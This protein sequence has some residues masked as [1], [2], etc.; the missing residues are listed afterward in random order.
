[1]QTGVY[2]LSRRLYLYTLGEPADP[3]ARDIVAFA[4]SDEAQGAVAEAGFVDQS[5]EMEDPQL[6]AK[7]IET[8]MG[9]TEPRTPAT[10]LS[11]LVED[12]RRV[13]RTSVNFRFAKGGFELDAKARLDAGRVA[14]FLRSPETS[15][16][17]WYLVGFADATGDYASNLALS[18]RRAGAVAN[19]LR[20]LGVRVEK[21]NIIPRGWVAPIACNS[22]EQGRALNRRVELWIGEPDSSALASGSIA[23]PAKKP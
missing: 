14:R 21:A 16:K 7:W 19:A 5:V 22:D 9:R 2:P 23:A 20:S 13:T 18:G 4:K 3:V 17:P 15:G 10:A 1:V 6:E 12:M 11:D 8:A